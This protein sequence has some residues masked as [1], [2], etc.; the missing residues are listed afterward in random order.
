MRRRLGRARAVTVAVLVV[1]LAGPGWSAASA[2]A[3]HDEIA[4]GASGQ[5][6][7][8]SHDEFGLPLASPPDA[9]AATTGWRPA[10]RWK[11]EVEEVMQ[12]Q[13]ADEHGRLASDERRD[14]QPS[15]TF[16]L[17]KD[18]DRYARFGAAFTEA[19]VPDCLREDGLKRQPPRILFFG[20]QG[21]LAFPFVALAKIRGKCL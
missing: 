8:S 19:K 21:V 12:A 17:V 18:S 13:E 9:A 11:R 15:A 3:P 2:T 4:S 5:N 16:G 6:P 14:T 20:F 1:V 10:Q 7:A